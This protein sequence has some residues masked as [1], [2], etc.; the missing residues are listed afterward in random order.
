MLTCLCNQ[1]CC[2]F[3]HN[4]NSNELISILVFATIFCTWHSSSASGPVQK[5]ATP[6]P[7]PATI[8]SAGKWVAIYMLIIMHPT[9]HHNIY[10]QPFRP[11]TCPGETVPGLP[12]SAS[13]ME[14]SL[15]HQQSST[16]PWVSFP[17]CTYLHIKKMYTSHLPH[18]H[19]SPCPAM[20]RRHLIFKWVAVTWLE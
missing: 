19:L 14:L 20:N 4:R 15:N 17:G 1:T 13:I 3:P 18:C 6:G 7:Q 5:P 12:T 2:L 9:Y 16:S 8:S 10:R 11:M